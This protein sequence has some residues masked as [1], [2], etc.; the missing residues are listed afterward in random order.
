MSAVRESWNRYAVAWADRH[1]GY[2]LRRA[3]GPVRRWQR[4]AYRVARPLVRLR[5]AP[6]AVGVL[7]AAVTVAVPVTALLGGSW[8]MV[9]AALV[10]LST[11]AGA[12]E[13]AVAVQGRWASR[14]GAVREAVAARLTEIAWLVTLWLV[15]VAGPLVV[16]CGVLTGLHEYLRSQALG[17]G[18]S[19]IGAQTAGDRPM[20]VAVTVVGLT[21]AGLTGPGLAAGVATVAASVWLCLGLLG[22]VQLVGAVRRS[23]L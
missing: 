6:V 12:V 21:L 20:R 9:A 22:L 23:L 5:V 19:R 13:A 15:G 3:P 17:V 2:D 14:R 4:L 16:A 10:V 11:F 8:P 18:M 7:A 1:G